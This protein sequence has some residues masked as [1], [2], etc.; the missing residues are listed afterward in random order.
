MLPKCPDIN[1][2]FTD[3]TLPLQSPSLIWG[4]T[5]C[6]FRLWEHCLG[7]LF[8]FLACRWPCWNLPLIPWDHPRCCLPPDWTYTV[9]KL[10][11]MAGT[12]TDRNWF[13]ILIM[14]ASHHQY[15]LCPALG[16]T[17]RIAGGLDSTFAGLY[18]RLH[19]HASQ[20]R[21]TLECRIMERVRLGFGMSRGSVNRF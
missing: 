14:I 12:N 9:I 21:Q 4:K 7:D 6:G 10:H 2:V 1:L 3:G 16:W 5:L 19:L 18:L 17:R 15:R 8:G 11:P 20:L 13:D